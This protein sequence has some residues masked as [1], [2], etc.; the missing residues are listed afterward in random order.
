MRALIITSRMSARDKIE[1]FDFMD[2][3]R[4]PYTVACGNASVFFVSEDSADEIFDTFP[5][6]ELDIKTAITSLKGCKSAM[7][8]YGGLT[9]DIEFAIDY[10]GWS[11]ETL[12]PTGI[13]KDRNG[14]ILMRDSFGELVIRNERLF[15]A[16]ADFPNS[17]ITCDYTYYFIDLNNGCGEGIYPMREFLLKDA[18]ADWIEK[19]KEHN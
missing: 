13:C 3:N 4:I 18:V 15:F 19:T 17:Y 2:S 6:I 11:R 16:L 5:F 1:L 12:V 7:E 9:M 8:L 10:N 14:F